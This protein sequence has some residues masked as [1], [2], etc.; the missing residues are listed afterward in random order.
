VLQV[1]EENFYGRIIILKANLS[2]SPTPAK[3]CQLI[4]C[5]IVC[6]STLILYDKTPSLMS[7][8]WL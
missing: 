5:K 2:S 6:D 7:K 8:V 3:F 4:H 1:W